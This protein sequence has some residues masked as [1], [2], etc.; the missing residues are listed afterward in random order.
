MAPIVRIVQDK[1]SKRRA[2]YSIRSAQSQSPQSGKLHLGNDGRAREFELYDAQQQAILSAVFSRL[3]LVVG[4]PGT[5]KT[6]VTACIVRTLYLNFCRPYGMV[7]GTI[8]SHSQ[9]QQQRA[10]NSH[11]ESCITEAAMQPDWPIEL[12]A[13]APT[14]QKIL[15]MTHS[16]DALDQLVERLTI[17]GVPVLRMG[18]RAT[19][20][21]ASSCT[22]TGW[23]ERIHLA[24]TASLTRLSDPAVFDKRWPITTIAADYANDNN[25]TNALRAL[26]QALSRISSIFDEEQLTDSVAQRIGIREPQPRAFLRRQKAELVFLRDALD[27]LQERSAS[28][29]RDRI[30]NAASVVTMTCSGAAMRDAAL[31]RSFHTV[32][33]EEAG[34]VL[35]TES[36]IGLVSP[37][38]SRLI[39]VGD[40]QQMRSLVLHPLLR[41]QANLDQS[42]FARLQRVGVQPILLNQQSRALPAVRTRPSSIRCSRHWRWLTLLRNE[43]AG[44]SLSLEIQRPR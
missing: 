13:L 37:S 8:S 24:V 2:E 41:Y 42:L 3:T 25:A 30:V 21:L 10:T 29:V 39:V 19:T 20:D 18:A 32:V 38:L 15:L 34:K 33:I 27:L 43:T 23:R 5:G 4:P 12:L 22:A 16:N 9:Q 40:D 28:K 14:Q 31:M 6:T 17:L 1:R 35:E 26:N 36:A 44:Q 7:H 11:R